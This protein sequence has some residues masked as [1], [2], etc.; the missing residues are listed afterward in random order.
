MTFRRAEVIVDLGAIASNV[1]A[2]KEKA[3][4]PILAV[5]KADAY[6]HGLVPVARVA[7]DAGAQWLGV[8][9]LEEALA[10]RESGVRAPV[11][12][13]LVPPGSDFATAIA[14][15]IDLGVAS[16]EI[17][18]EIC[19]AAQHMNKRARIHVEVDTGMTRGG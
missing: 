16:L 6:G 2:L 9:L 1:R 14:S 11:I 10:L 18:Y 19:N 4:V 5:V 3:G 12:A 13:W 17:F 8:A 7:I 15:D